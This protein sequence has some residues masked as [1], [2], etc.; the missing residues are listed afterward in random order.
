MGIIALVTL[1]RSSSDAKTPAGELMEEIRRAIQS[2]E[3][4]KGWSIE[5]ISVLGESEIL[6]ADVSSSTS[7]KTQ[8]YGD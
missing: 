6:A 4:S 3:I 1:I 7:K 2:S 5:K 8:L